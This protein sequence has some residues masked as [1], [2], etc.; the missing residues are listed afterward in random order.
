[1]EYLFIDNTASCD[2]ALGIFIRDLSPDV[3]Y[4]D[5]QIALFDGEWFNTVQNGDKTESVLFENLTPSNKYT[6]HAQIKVNGVWIDLADTT[7]TTR[8]GGLLSTP[9]PSMFHGISGVPVQNPI[10]LSEV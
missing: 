9:L 3:T 7:F 10:P 5:F 6:F 8:R 2:T 1:M 4:E